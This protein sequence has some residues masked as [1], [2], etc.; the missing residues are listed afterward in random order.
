[1]KGGAPAMIDLIA[2]QI[3]VVFAPTQ[4]GLPQARAGRVRALAVTSAE[5]IPAEPQLPTIAESGV[6]GYEAANWFAVIGPRGVPQPVVGRMNREINRAIR[7]P[8]V[9][10]RAAAGGLPPGGRT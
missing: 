9:V 2:G 4:T 1:Y 7:L 6:P 10:E 5:R 3:S 8:D